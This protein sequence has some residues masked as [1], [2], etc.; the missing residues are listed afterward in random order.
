MNR[1]SL[2]ILMGPSGVG[3][4]SLVRELVRRLG[5][6]GVVWIPSFTTRAPRP[7]ECEGVDYFFVSLE[8]FNQLKELGALLESSTAY[9]ASYGVGREVVNR[10]LIEGKIALLPIDRRGAREIKAQI[11]EVKIILIVPPSPE[12]LRE[13]LLKRSSE[14][15]ET[16][17]FRLARALKEAEEEA[18]H[19]L[20]DVVVINDNFEETVQQLC[21]LV[22]QS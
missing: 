11:K 14:A 16:I 13:R 6:K 5:D 12:I 20:A 17:E 15:A 19:P 21:A 18:A 3:K 9:T 4:T 1:G 10:A 8:R 22:L 7:G 2:F